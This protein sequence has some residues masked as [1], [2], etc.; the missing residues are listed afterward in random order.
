MLTELPCLPF[1]YTDCF[2]P[3]SSTTLH[4][5][6]ARFL[7]LLDEHFWRVSR[8]LENC[9]ACS[10][11][12]SDGCCIARV[13]GC[14]RAGRQVRRLQIGALVTVRGVGRLTLVGLTQLE[15]FIRGR[16][17]PLKD[18][19]NRD[20]AAVQVAVQELRAVLADVQQL[21]IK[22]KVRPCSFLLARVLARG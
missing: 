14:A 18:K 11:L 13:R 3:S 6:E 5:Y 22:L 12:R 7:A 20:E 9:A 1:P 10:R 21:Q 2:V 8:V 16:V 17:M 19:A 4:L 15:P